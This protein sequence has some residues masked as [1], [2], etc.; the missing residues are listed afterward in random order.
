MKCD[1]LSDNLSLQYEDRTSHGLNSLESLVRPS[2]Q[3]LSQLYGSLWRC[4]E[5]IWVC[6][7]S[8]V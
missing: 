5:C 1:C 2:L 8:V 4:G 6:Y 7:K 3:F